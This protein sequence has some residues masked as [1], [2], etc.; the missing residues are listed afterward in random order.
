MHNHHTFLS[1]G[2]RT[3]LAALLLFLAAVGSYGA[4]THEGF[5]RAPSRRETESKPSAEI[6][7]IWKEF[8]ARSGEPL[9]ASWNPGSGTDRK[10]TRL[11]SSH[12]EISYAVFCLKKKKKKK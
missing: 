12:V 8:V 6:L 3:R 10:S 1:P 5:Q 7:P 11:N 4:S 9:A 2:L